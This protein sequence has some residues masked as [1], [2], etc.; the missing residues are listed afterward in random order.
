MLQLPE[1]QLFRTER[2]SKLFSQTICF[3]VSS[4]WCNSDSDLAG[5]LTHILHEL[6]LSLIPPLVNI[7]ETQQTNPDSSLI[8]LVYL[9]TDEGNLNHQLPK[10]MTDSLNQQCSSHQ[11]PGCTGPLL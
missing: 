9:V 7:Q 3:H 6:L 10:L 1:L 11:H 8:V 4:G 2:D 5:L